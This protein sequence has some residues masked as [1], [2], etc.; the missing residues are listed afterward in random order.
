MF[1]LL[2]SILSNDALQALSLAPIYREEA[3]PINL[4]GI[5][6]PSFCILLIEIG[7][8]GSVHFRNYEIPIS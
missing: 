1:F 8:K 3:R 6:M 4:T 2:A 7:V 5:W